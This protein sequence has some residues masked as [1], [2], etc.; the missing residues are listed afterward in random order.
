MVN[1][2][3][4]PLVIPQSEKVEPKPLHVCPG[5]SIHTYS[6]NMIQMQCSIKHRNYSTHNDMWI[7][8][9]LHKGSGN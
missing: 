4:K 9:R 8:K 3:L 6:N 1:I 7:M 5:Y 2:A